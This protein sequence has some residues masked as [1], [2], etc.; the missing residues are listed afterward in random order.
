M[1][2]KNRTRET[3]KQSTISF[4][5]EDRAASQGLERGWFR[6]HRLSSLLEPLRE[7][8]TLYDTYAQRCNQLLIWILQIQ[9]MPYGNCLLLSDGPINNSTGIPFF[10]VTPKDNTVTDLLKNPMA[11]LTLPEADGNFCR[12]NVIDPEDPRC[13]RLTLT[14]QMVTVP[15]EEVEFAK[16]AM[17]SRHPVVR[18]WPRSYEWFFMKMNIEHIWLQSWYGEVSPIAV[19][20]Y[21]K[22]APSKG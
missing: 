21:L 7:S 15:P 11:S 8:P 2:P 18:K 1:H 10:Y 9:G 3:A 20:E 4:R 5:P 6:R 22:A 19:E 13:T 14:G 17:F 12:K 16:Q